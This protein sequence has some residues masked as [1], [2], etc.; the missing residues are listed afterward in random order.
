V[1]VA[2]GAVAE[3]AD[4]QVVHAVGELRGVDR[5]GVD[6]VAERVEI[7]GAVGA[8]EFLEPVGGGAGGDVID[9]SVAVEVDA[10]VQLEQGVVAV[11]V[12][13]ADGAEQIDLIGAALLRVDSPPF[14][15]AACG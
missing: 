8:G 10:A 7:A 12:V 6:A 5:L 9:V 14:S 1:L 4:G 3:G 2:V 11:G 15:W 13:V